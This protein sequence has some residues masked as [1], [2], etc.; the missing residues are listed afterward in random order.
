[1][2]KDNIQKEI[3]NQINNVY[4][5]IKS[6]DELTMPE[7]DDL[8]REIDDRIQLINQKKDDIDEFYEELITVSESKFNELKADFDAKMKELNKDV[9]S[10]RERLTKN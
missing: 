6:I 5:K 3:K 8:Q 1:M 7:E 2:D 9:Q 10:V 4:Q